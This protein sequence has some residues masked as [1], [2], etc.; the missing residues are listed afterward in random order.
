M[1]YKESKIFVSAVKAQATGEES[2]IL[3]LN[4]IELP[5][6]LFGLPANAV[7]TERIDPLQ[8]DPTAGVR[9]TDVTVTQVH[10]YSNTILH[11]YCFFGRRNLIGSSNS[12]TAFNCRL[13]LLLTFGFASTS[14]RGMR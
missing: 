10:F 2:P 5:W 1:R 7:D 6:E 12:R 14:S 3:N 11:E 8:L 4:T 13:I 9:L